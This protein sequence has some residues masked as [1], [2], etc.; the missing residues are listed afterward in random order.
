[1]LYIKGGKIDAKKALQQQLN[2]E[3]NNNINQTKYITAARY[4]EAFLYAYKDFNPEETEVDPE[5]PIEKE[6][7]TKAP[8]YTKRNIFE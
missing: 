6:E 8:S 3:T 7:L 2:M 5:K 4:N 1:M